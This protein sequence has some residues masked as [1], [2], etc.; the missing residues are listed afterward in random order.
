MVN[1]IIAEVMP[2][3][4]GEWNFR[5]PEIHP[6]SAREWQHPRPKMAA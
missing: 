4:G 5:C 3:R 2:F 6:A 1:G